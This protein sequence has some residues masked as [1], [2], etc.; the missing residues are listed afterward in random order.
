MHL[1][2]DIVLDPHRLSVQGSMEI[3]LGLVGHTYGC[4]VIGILIE[5]FFSRAHSP[6][7]P[8]NCIYKSRDANAS[9]VTDTFLSPSPRL[10][11]DSAI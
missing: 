4:I 7:K 9:H 11:Q 1:L 6:A 10:K 3:R 2:S 8:G 5:N